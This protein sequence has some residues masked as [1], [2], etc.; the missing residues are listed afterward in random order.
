MKKNKPL[1]ELD[2]I[3][4]TGTVVYVY[5]KE[6][7]EVEIVGKNGRTLALFTLETK[8]LEYEKK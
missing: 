2:V 8:G 7:V 5:S 6:V 4:L 1:K 3:T